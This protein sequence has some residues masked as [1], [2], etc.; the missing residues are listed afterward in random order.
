MWVLIPYNDRV[1]IGFYTPNGGWVS[2]LNMPDMIEA[3][4]LIHYLNGGD[5]LRLPDNYIKYSKY[6]PEKD[7]ATESYR[8]D[9]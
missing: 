2:L 5:D 4:G 8:H 1:E 9:G 7:P 6:H 3:M